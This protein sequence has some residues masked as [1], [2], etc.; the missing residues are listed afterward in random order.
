MGR[1]S[2]DGCSLAF[3]GGFRELQ[4]DL[5]DQELAALAQSRDEIQQELDVERQEHASAVQ[6]LTAALEEARAEVT[7]SQ[8]ACSCWVLVNLQHGWSLFWRLIVIRLLWRSNA[9]LQI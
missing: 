9:C 7:V 4:R 6:K 8:I 5:L 3:G 2:P 1:R